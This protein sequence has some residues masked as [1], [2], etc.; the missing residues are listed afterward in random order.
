[1]RHA[2]YPIYFKNNMSELL[3]LHSD[4]LVEDIAIVMARDQNPVYC[5]VV[6]RQQIHYYFVVLH[7]FSIF[8]CQNS[9]RVLSEFIQSCLFSSTRCDLSISLCTV[10]QLTLIEDWRAVISMY[11][12]S[13][14][15]QCVEHFASGSSKK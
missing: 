2:F 3:Q 7:R 4:S 15:W 11:T 5:L 13:L 6:Y 9:G 12:C 14:R 10:S 1:M 8:G